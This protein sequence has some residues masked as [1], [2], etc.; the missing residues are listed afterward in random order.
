MPEHAEHTLLEQA[1]SGDR[2]AFDRLQTALDAPVRRF[3][4]RL[5]GQNDAEEDIARGVFLALYMNL[6]RLEN[7]E[8]LRPFVFRV[9][10]NL[11]YDEQRRKGRFQVV[12]LDSSG[13]DTDAPLHVLRD[14]AP[15]PDE[16]AHWALLY[17]EVQKAMEHLPEPQRQAL[18]L[19][20]EED[21]T[22]AQI[23]EVMAIDLGTVKSRIH[24]AR[25][26]LVRRLKP[27][28]REALG[29]QKEN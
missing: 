21:L 26:N 17:D 7:P 11:C 12:S 14:G 25:K 9:V 20:C 22:Y 23:A 2:A 13:E 5:I 16:V 15:P 8:H 24:H 4:R 19:F 6:E 18:I 1:R 27:G 3:T 28:I 29:I 10:R